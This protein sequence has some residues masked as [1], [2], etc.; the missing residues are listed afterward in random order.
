MIK[1]IMINKFLLNVNIK[2][3]DTRTQRN[4]NG[5]EWDGTKPGNIGNISATI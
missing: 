5:A 4:E 3:I 1:T 2:A